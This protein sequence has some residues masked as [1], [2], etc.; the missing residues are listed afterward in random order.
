MTRAELG[1]HSGRL[2]RR[3][4][5]SSSARSSWKPSTGLGVWVGV[6]VGLGL[7]LGVGS[8]LEL[9]AAD[10]AVSTDGHHARRETHVEGG[11]HLGGDEVEVRWR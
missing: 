3:E 8:G 9:E 1:F 5:R 7:E 6:G 4:R 11:E 10:L 2:L